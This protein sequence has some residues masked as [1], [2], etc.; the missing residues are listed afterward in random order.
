MKPQTA[1]WVGF[2]SYALLAL[3]LAFLGLPLYLN[4][5]K[6]YVEQYSVDL[7]TLGVALL[8]L[9]LGDAFLD[10]LIGRWSD[11]HARHRR[12]IFIVSAIICACAFNALFIPPI[13]SPLIWFTVFTALTYFSYSVLTINYYSAGLQQ[14][15]GYQ[16]R[17]Q[18]SAFREGSAL[19]GTLFA[20]LLPQVLLASFPALQ[21]FQLYGLVF[22]GVMVIGMAGILPRLK[23]IAVPEQ[24]PLLSLIDLLK[25]NK[26]LSW[27][28]GLFF[29][30]ALPTA[31]TSTLFL[32]YADDVLHA[33]DSAGYFL[34]VYFFAAVCSTP[35]W[36]WLSARLGKRRSLMLAMVL[37]MGSF[38]WAYALGSG[39][40]HAFYI[41]CVLSGFAIG[42][43]MILLPSLLADVLEGQDE[44]GSTGFGLWH[45]LSKWSLA[46]AAGISLPLLAAFGYVPNQ[47]HAASV[48]AIVSVAYALI[49]CGFKV[50]ALAILSISPLDRRTP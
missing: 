19:I 2:L 11:K 49:P 34:A 44:H 25:Q 50:I 14:A 47:I 3:P 16:E 31:I 15:R 6:F 21:S 22:T 12:S 29:F 45:A 38:V 37:A 5:P 30:N 7:S 32:F 20:A 41:I 4:L 23:Q 28:L 36:S 48:E 33:K 27:L 8:C 35:C 26:K 39:D 9:R 17:T 18:L 13:G 1:S 43:D 42:A 24:R 46:L 10:P 40:T